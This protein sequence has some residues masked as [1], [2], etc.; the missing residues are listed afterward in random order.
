MPKSNRKR[1]HFDIFS[2]IRD[3]HDCHMY[4]T[5][6]DA[7]ADLN[8]PRVCYEGCPIFV[9]PDPNEALIIAELLEQI[10]WVL[11]RKADEQGPLT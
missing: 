4:E 8:A 9:K 1:V 11:N 10:Q 6:L 7:A 3:H 2:R 5:C